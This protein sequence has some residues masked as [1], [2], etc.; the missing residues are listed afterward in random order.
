MPSMPT[1]PPPRNRWRVGRGLGGWNC[2]M[3]RGK[4]ALVVSP[5]DPGEGGGAPRGGQGSRRAT[6]EGSAIGEAGWLAVGPPPVAGQGLCLA[7]ANYSTLSKWHLGVPFL[8][9][10][11]AG[12]PC[13]LCG[14][15]VDVFGDH[16]VSCKTS[17]F[18]D[19]HLGTQSVFCQV[20]TQAGSRM[21]ARWT[22]PGMADAQRTS[23]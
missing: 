18:G 23:C 20:L 2:P 15:P 10:D 3:G 1:C 19:R 9:A 17:G 6:P 16:A 12:R 11:C 22:S 7:G 14:G 8:P 4:S 21:T 5:P 13:L